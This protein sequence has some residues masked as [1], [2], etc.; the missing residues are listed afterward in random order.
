MWTKMSIG[1][2]FG[3]ILGQVTAP[4]HALWIVVG[5]TAAY[6]AQVW[7]DRARHSAQEGNEV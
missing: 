7:V 4:G 3:L 2:L 5:I 1:A 6:A